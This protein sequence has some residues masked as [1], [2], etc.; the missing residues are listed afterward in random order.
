MWAAR[1]MSSRSDMLLTFLRPDPEPF[2]LTPDLGAGSGG[3]AVFLLT[4]LTDWGSFP[5]WW[6]PGLKSHSRQCSHTADNFV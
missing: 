5:K 1:S 4:S 3:E 6:F 2:S